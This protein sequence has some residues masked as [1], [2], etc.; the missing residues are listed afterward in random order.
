M[1]AG[2]FLKVE[3]LKPFLLRSFLLMLWDS[4]V[5]GRGKQNPLE[6][7]TG[8]RC[9]DGLAHLYSQLWQNYVVVGLRKDR[10]G[11]AEM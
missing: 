5:A 4:I 1:M 2:G 9:R 11:E 8:E 10:K 3:F 7:V 6:T